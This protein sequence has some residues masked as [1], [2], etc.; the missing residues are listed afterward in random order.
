MDRSTT[1]GYELSVT[2]TDPGS[3]VA[4]ATVFVCVGNMTNCFVSAGNSGNGGGGAA[5]IYGGLMP[6]FFSLIALVL[7]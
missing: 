2:A 5:T 4:T 7:Y 1:P 3:N 6:I